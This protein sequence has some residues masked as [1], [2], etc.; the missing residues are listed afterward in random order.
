MAQHIMVNRTERVV[1]RSIWLITV[2]MGNSVVKVT[3]LF[4]FNSIQLQ[5]HSLSYSSQ[6]AQISS[7]FQ[8]TAGSAFSLFKNLFLIW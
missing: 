8:E 2:T 6:N 4:S 7:Y 3:S 1:V 5:Q